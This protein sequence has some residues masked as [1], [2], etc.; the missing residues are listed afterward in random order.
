MPILQIKLSLLP[1]Y[2]N[3]SHLNSGVAKIQNLKYR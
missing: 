2:Y 1:A 3:A